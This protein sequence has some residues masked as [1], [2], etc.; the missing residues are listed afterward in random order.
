M[1]ATRTLL[2]LSLLTTL[3]WS[4]DNEE[5]RNERRAIHRED[6]PALMG[7]VRQD[8]DRGVRGVTIAADRVARAFVVEDRARVADE[9]RPVMRNFRRP[10]RR[11]PIHELMNTPVT[12]I[13]AVGMDGRVIAR[14]IDPDPMA[15]F[16]IAEVAPVVQR[17]LEGSTGYE[18][19]E[20]PSLAE[21]DM[22]SVTILF[23][24]P[25]RHQ[26][27]VVGAMVAGLPL[28]RIGQQMTRQLQLDNA[29]AVRRGELIWVLLLKGDQ[30]HHHRAF[31][32]GLLN[33]VPDAERRAR[34][35]GPSPHGFT[36]QIR[37]YSRW[38]GYGV[39]PVPAIA[40][41]VQ[42]VVFRSEPN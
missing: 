8:L 26:G 7:I 12:F 25:S 24:A 18:L 31:P 5:G 37:Q 17:A 27:R 15:G 13:A 32:P 4:C 38:Y 9:L 40:D 10:E 34:G 42:I 41:D 21:G 22:A 2:S 39:I 20:L 36:A 29:P 1:K 19:S 14:D 16:D 35:L 33:M 30:P 6:V 3:L 23:A 28:W 11:N